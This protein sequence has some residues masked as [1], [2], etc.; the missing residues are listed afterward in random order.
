[1]SKTISEIT[2]KV[3][4]KIGRLPAGQSATA[5]QITTVGDAYDGL[6]QELLILNIV[7]WAATDDIPDE[8][9]NSIQILLAGRVASDF[10]VPDEWSQF[11]TL[12]KQRLSA[13]I[14]SAYIPQT[15]RFEDI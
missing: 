5:G 11:E 6:Y 15:T 9:S 2:T 14:T 12:M 8:A 4:T 10:G 1:M 3:L 7:G 13:Q